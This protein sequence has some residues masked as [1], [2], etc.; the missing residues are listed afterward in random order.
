MLNALVSN[1]KSL[2]MLRARLMSGMVSV[3]TNYKLPAESICGT[4]I[5][6]NSVG[7][8][9]NQTHGGCT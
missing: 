5:K 4:I 9:M 1:V 7:C 2:C 8:S 3:M 6:C